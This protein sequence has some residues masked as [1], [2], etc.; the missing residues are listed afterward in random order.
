MVA[1]ALVAQAVWG[2]ARNLCTD[3]ARISIAVTTTCI[4]IAWPNAWGQFGVIS[5]AALIGSVWF[6]P[7]QDIANDPLPISVCR[8]VGVASLGM[9]FSLLVGLPIVLEAYRSQTLAIIAAFYRT[10]SL[11]FGGGHVVL[12]L[13]QAATVASGLVIERNLFGRI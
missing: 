10:G 13:L 1:V 12:P 6:K 7:I 5:A 11:V 3:T 8:R 2:M 4:V 9:F